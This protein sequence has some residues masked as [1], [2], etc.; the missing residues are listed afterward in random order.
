MTPEGFATFKHEAVH[1]L[2]E[3]NARCDR[4]FSISKWPRW[5][6]DMDLGRLVFSEEGVPKVSAAIEAVGT[7]SKSDNTWMWSWAN[8]SLPARVVAEI[9][10][11]R[12]F[13][14]EESISL[15]TEAVL[16]DDECLGWELTGVTARILGSRGAYRCPT[17]GGLS[18]LCP[19]IFG[20][21]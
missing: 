21:H 16:P 4:E 5:D 3:L 17:D 20:S 19:W 14:L 15:L 11:V 12:D 18:T 1:A 2:M 8:D 7:T 10:K 6:Y 9:S 13:G